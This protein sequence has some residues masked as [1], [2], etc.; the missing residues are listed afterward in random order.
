M[1]VFLLKRLGVML[2]TA[3]CLTLIVFMLVNLKPNLVKLAKEQTGRGQ[4]V[5]S[6][7]RI[8]LWRDL[9]ARMRSAR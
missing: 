5:G 7:D 6:S 2:L 1:V 4:S 9:Q 8:S 3:L